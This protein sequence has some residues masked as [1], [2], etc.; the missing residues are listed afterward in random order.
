MKRNFPSGLR[1]ALHFGTCVRRLR[2]GYW[3]HNSRTSRKSASHVTPARLFCAYTFVMLT[4]PMRKHEIVP[5]LVE[6]SG[7]RLFASDLLAF[8]HPCRAFLYLMHNELTHFGPHVWI[9]LQ[10]C[11]G[12]F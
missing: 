5:G 8:R 7:S 2:L 4:S 3:H 12:A 6:S 1:P 11:M 10:F 9:E